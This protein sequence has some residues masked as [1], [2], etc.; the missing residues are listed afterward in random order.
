[1][2]GYCCHSKCRYCFLFLSVLVDARPISVLCDL[3]LHLVQKVSLW[4]SFCRGSPP[5]AEQWIRGLHVL[6]VAC[7]LLLSWCWFLGWLPCELFTLPPFND[8]LCILGWTWLLANESTIFTLPLLCV[9]CNV[10]GQTP[11]SGLGVDV[12]IAALD[13]CVQCICQAVW[14]CSEG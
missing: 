13:C 11:L 14:G 6:L 7:E 12:S 8:F 1:M 9:G 5:Q 2:S 3:D 4:Q 10:L